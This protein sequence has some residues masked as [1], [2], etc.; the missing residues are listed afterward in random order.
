MTNYLRPA[1]SSDTTATRC[2]TAATDKG[3]ANRRCRSGHSETHCV[4]SV[5]CTVFRS[6]EG[7]EEIILT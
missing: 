3:V 1:D 2:Y 5:D 4:G 6:E 7:T